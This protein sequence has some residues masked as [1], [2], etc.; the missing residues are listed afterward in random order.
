MKVGPVIE[1][2][3]DPRGEAP[4]RGGSNFPV[5]PPLGPRIEDHHRRLDQFETKRRI[6][7]EH[8]RGAEL[9]EAVIDPIVAGK[10]VQDGASRCQHR[11]EICERIRH[12]KHV[13]ERS[14]VHDQSK[15]LARL[16]RRLRLIEIED[17]VRTV[18]VADVQGGQR[19]ETEDFEQLTCAHGRRRRRRG[20]LSCLSRSG[21][22]R[23]QRRCVFRAR[24]AD[25]LYTQRQCWTRKSMAARPIVHHYC[26][27]DVKFHAMELLRACTY[28]LVLRVTL[29]SRPFW[30]V[31]SL[32][33]AGPPVLRQAL[34]G[35]TCTSTKDAVKISVVGS[36]VNCSASRRISYLC[37]FVPAKATVKKYTPPARLLK[38]SSR[39]SPT[40]PALIAGDFISGRVTSD[41][42][43]RESQPKT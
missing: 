5:M 1:R 25:V 36:T 11:I 33:N 15:V 18:V 26:E 8:Q 37:S 6:I 38:K 4:D 21:M 20:R 14:A 10:H 27:V 34:A 19:S 35:F 39:T 29:C 16:R 23:C 40:D 13:L 2:A 9:I 3:C 30:P 41:P 12:V 28:L 31:T 42:P 43:Q 22:R 7:V 17:D 32:H 24:E